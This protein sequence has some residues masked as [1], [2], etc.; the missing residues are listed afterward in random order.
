KKRFAGQ[1]RA[2]QEI[3][4][5]CT[6]TIIKQVDDLKELVNEFSTFARLP[7]A[8]PTPNALS[9]VVQEAM[10]LFQEGH[11]GIRFAF[12]ELQEIPILSLDR[13]QIKRVFINLFDNAVFAMKGRG[14]IHVTADY[15]KALQMVTVE[16]SDTGPGIPE[17]IK[18][19][20]FEPYFS[21]K[22][23]GTGLGLSIVKRII[24]DHNGFIRV[25]DNQ[26]KGTT[27]IIEL[28]AR[29]SIRPQRRL[30]QGSRIETSHV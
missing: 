23:A 20:L 7:E 4:E 19:R 14:E 10:V 8:N 6:T 30:I 26:P 29:P 11:K 17:E 15:K 25:A 1:I 5:E 18:P 21:T 9:E 24:T 13:E 2:G 27:F 12:E 3:F 22:D 28:P 16:V